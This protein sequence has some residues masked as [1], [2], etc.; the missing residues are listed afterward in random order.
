[1]HGTEINIT[2]I[3]NKQKSKSEEIVSAKVNELE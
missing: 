3:A 2:E 1:M